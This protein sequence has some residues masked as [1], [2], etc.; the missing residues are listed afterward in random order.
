MAI[1]S[2][3]SVF[4]HM[5]SVCVASIFAREVNA[6]VGGWVRFSN[7]MATD[8][9]LRRCPMSETTAKGTGLEELAGKEDPVELVPSIFWL[10]LAYKKR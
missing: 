9:H 7:I 1:I 8:A 4:M 6:S 2:N 10:I 3:R 5:P